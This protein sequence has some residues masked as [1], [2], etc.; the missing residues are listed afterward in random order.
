MNTFGRNGGFEWFYEMCTLPEVTVQHHTKLP[1]DL[2]IEDEE[3]GSASESKAAESNIVVFEPVKVT[4]AEVQSWANL[5]ARL[6][7]LM[8]P[9]APTLN[10]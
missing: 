5:V 2:D 9:F 6:L 3:A 10:M 8:R 1:G 4:N 7:D